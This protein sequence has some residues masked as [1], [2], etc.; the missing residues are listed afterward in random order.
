MYSWE[1]DAT[2]LNAAASQ[3]PQSNKD[4]QTMLQQSDADQQKDKSK[5][6]R[7]KLTAESGLSDL[8]SAVKPVFS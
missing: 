5:G 4:H 1:Y 6:L 3:W 8:S 2:L 7:L